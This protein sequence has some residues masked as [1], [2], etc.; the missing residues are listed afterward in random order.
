[1]Q[2]PLPEVVSFAGNSMTMMIGSDKELESLTPNICINGV[3]ISIWSVQQWILRNNGWWQKIV[4]LS[5]E[6]CVASSNTSTVVYHMPWSQPRLCRNISVLCLKN[7]IENNRIYTVY[8]KLWIPAID[9]NRYLFLCFNTTLRLS[10]IIESRKTVHPYHREWTTNFETPF[11]WRV[12][13]LCEESEHQS[14]SQEENWKRQIDERII[15]FH[16]FYRWK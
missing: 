7:S 8:D 9:N 11:Q 16:M 14:E 6:I 13:W 4:L 10:S 15:C 1:M 12:T 3:Y 5:K 2:P